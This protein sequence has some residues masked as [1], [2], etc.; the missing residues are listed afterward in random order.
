[1]TPLLIACFL[2]AAPVEVEVAPDQPLNF[3]YV[4]DPL[5]VELRSDTDQT[6]DANIRIVPA[7][8]GPALKRNFPDVP[9]RAAAARWLA[10]EDLPPRRGYYNAKVQIAGGG[11]ADKVAHEIAFCRIDRPRD[12]GMLPVYARNPKPDPQTTVALRHAGIHAV[13]FSADAPA[14]VDKVNFFVSRGFGVTVRL[15]AAMLDEIDLTALAPM[16]ADWEVSAGDVPGVKRTVRAIR[17]AGS[18]GG[19]VVVVRDVAEF[20]RLLAAG[21]GD[22]VREI[23]LEGPDVSLRA[24]AEIRQAASAAGF[25][26]W[27][28][29]AGRLEETGAAGLATGLINHIGFGTRR[30]GIDPEA[31]VEEALKAPYIWLHGLAQH[32]Q[33][34][35]QTGM[36]GLGDDVHAPVF[37][38]GARWLIVLWTDGE[39]RRIE[40]E[41]PKV[42]ELAL[43]DGA[44]NALPAP[45]PIANVVQFDVGPEPRYL[46]GVGGGIVGRAAANRALNL[47]RH[48]AENKVYRE[49]LPQSLIDQV[50]TAAK[51]RD[52]GLDRTVFFGM[53]REF[54]ELEAQW[55]EGK[56]PRNVAAPALYDL[57]QIVRALCAAEERSEEPFL[58]PLGDTLARCDDY[59]SIYITDTVAESQYR[60]D[61]L[62]DEVR[63]LA[64]EAKRLDDAGR[65]IEASA[66]AAMAEWRARALEAA[67]K[68]GANSARMA[69]VQL[70]A[71]EPETQVDDADGDAV[72]S[73]VVEQPAE[74]EM[75]DDE[76]METE[77]DTATMAAAESETPETASAPEA[78][79]EAPVEET[80]D[81]AP[82][83]RK[84]HIVKSG[85]NPSLIAAKHGVRLSD[86]LKWNNLNSRSRIDVGDKLLVSAP[87]Q[88]ATAAA[89]ADAPRDPGQPKGTQKIVHTVARGDT[90]AAI[91]KR[92]GVA[93]R[94]FERW[95]NLRHN[96]ALA[97]GKQYVV[98]VPADEA[99]AA[100]M[101]PGQPK[102][103][104][105]VVHTV[106]RGDSPYTI[107][108]KYSVKLDD[109]LKWNKLTKRSVLQ[110]RQKLTVYTKAR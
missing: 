4:D 61:W 10:I 6:V 7:D 104:K 39:D 93:Q 67:G 110:I 105:K 40:M 32:L 82:A 85:D 65:R 44:N 91:A 3:I 103:T 48:F 86:L 72:S 83:E 31:F 26:E 11:N 50:R 5:I 96:T 36:L 21:L 101:D 58:E 25:E 49:Y 100:P 51:A 80:A 62:L 108:Q 16:V 57:A 76:G 77:E 73:T 56:L 106:A 88:G 97:R 41:V 53:L 22:T 89:A 12:E 64:D 42:R 15:N 17:D 78:S 18:S 95:N 27:T 8:G 63:R 19:A 69:E 20:N 92:Y 68:A 74:A 66:L 94:D 102:G 2:L 87:V 84:V 70:A 38:S 9:L 109:L 79:P 37:R 54:P 13:R 34:V 1:M 90:P 14:L 99:S 35:E 107:A 98:Y 24:L 33:G 47:A 23:V 59:M 29:S 71:V 46:S 30:I 45:E 55:H 28:V 81:T 43:A 75:N 60:G 52:K